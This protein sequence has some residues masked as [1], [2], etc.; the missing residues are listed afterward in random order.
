MTS[1]FRLLPVDIEERL[2]ELPERVAPLEELIALWLFGSFARGEATPI[3]DVDLAYLARSDL[4][5]EALDR[6]EMELY[7]TI[8]DTLHTDEFTFANIQHAPAYFAWRVLREGKLLFCRND[9][10]V[11]RV[12]ETA[13]RHAP[14]VHWLRHVGNQD[15]LEGL[16]MSNPMIDKERVTELL[17]LLSEDIKDLQEKSK[18]SKEVYLSSRDIQ[19]VVERRA[20]TAIE[21]CINIGNHLI[22]R[23]GWRAPQDYADVF[24]ILQ[25]AQILP[26]ELAEAMMEMAR[27]RNLLVH[28]YWQIDHERVYQSLPG[29]LANLESFAQHIARWLRER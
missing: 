11:A 6:F 13:Y 12:A 21:S 10:S 18:L 14:D 24:R 16:R 17:R 5:D 7:R 29:R 3:S 23:L 28:L 1:K 27:F 19:A 20:Q 2:K 25:E 4:R 8:A 9:E 22:A 26:V 15:F